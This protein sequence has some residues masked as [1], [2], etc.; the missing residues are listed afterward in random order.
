MSIDPLGNEPIA[1]VTFPILKWRE[2]HGNHMLRPRDR[3]RERFVCVPPTG[4][5]IDEINQ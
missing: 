5:N 4:K 1:L 2:R 3:A